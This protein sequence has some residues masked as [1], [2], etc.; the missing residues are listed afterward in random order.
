MADFVR[1]AKRDNPDD[2]NHTVWLRNTLK[3]LYAQPH[4]WIR[5]PLVQYLYPMVLH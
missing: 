2:I 3:P 5:M 1:S 4:G